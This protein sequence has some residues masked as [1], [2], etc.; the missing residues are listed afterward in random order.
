MLKERLSLESAVLGKRDVH[1]WKTE[2]R[3]LSLVLIPRSTPEFCCFCWKHREPVKTLG[4]GKDFLQQLK[5][6]SQKLTS[7]IVT[8]WQASPEQ[9]K[10]LTEWKDSP[11][12]GRWFLVICHGL[13]CQLHKELDHIKIPKV[14][15][16]IKGA[17][18]YGDMLLNKW[19]VSME[20]WSI[21]SHQEDTH[22]QCCTT[23]PDQAEWVSPRTET[24][25]AGKGSG[26]GQLSVIMSI[27]P[28]TVE[29]RRYTV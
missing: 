22:H 14:I 28:V 19:P 17:M 1:M 15:Q 18:N 4:M 24:T 27:G 3:S 9:K 6:W 16:A 10:Q 5:R 7:N 21:L 23:P 12:H 2:S 11:H 29:V 25:G 8:S 13:K 26:K 20:K